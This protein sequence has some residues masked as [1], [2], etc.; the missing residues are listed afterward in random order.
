MKNKI[1]NTT[2]NFV[3][4]ALSD[5]FTGHD[6]EHIRRVHQLA[7]K[8]Q[9]KEGGNEFI[10]SMAALLH[11]LADWKLFNEQEANIK[12]I[13]FLKTEGLNEDE[14]DQII[15]IIA[16]VSYKGSGVDTTPTSLEAKIVQDADRLDAIGVIGV[17]RAFAYGAKKNRSMYNP[18][19]LPQT[20]DSF[21]EYKNSNSTTINHFYEKLLLIKDLLNTSTA[22]EIGN[23]RHEKVESFLRDFI[24]E[25]NVESDRPIFKEKIN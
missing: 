4:Q 15:N 22:K 2:I 6:W 21:E 12:I 11:D 8:I 5:D 17:A 18:D 23:K 14:M 1:V 19:I 7:L 9:S 3:K 25:W 20:H 13:N 10:V 24:Q 16:Q